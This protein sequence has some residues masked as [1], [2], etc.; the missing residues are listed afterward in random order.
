[1]YRWNTKKI[2]A[3]LETIE[4]IES[5]K[6]D[7]PGGD[8]DTENI[9]CK[10]RGSDDWIF[11]CGFSCEDEAI[12][13]TPYE[14]KGDIDIEMVEVTDRSGHGL[15]SDDFNVATAYIKVRQ[16]FVGGGAAVVDHLKDYF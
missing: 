11:A 6:V 3:Y 4:E 15:Q 2:V 12:W 8:C 10:V 14:E 5:V 7:M 16:H 1:M 13:D 9:R